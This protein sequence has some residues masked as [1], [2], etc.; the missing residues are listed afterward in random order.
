MQVSLDQ[1]RVAPAVRRRRI[2]RAFYTTMSLAVVATVIVGFARTYFLRSWF[3]DTALPLYLEIHGF[4]FTSWIALFVAQPMFV[5]S[6]R[7]D[8][9]RRLGW[10]GAV[11]ASSMV[12]VGITAAILSG[13]RDFADGSE[14]ESLTFLTT[15]FLSMLVFLILI[16]AAVL[17]RRVPEAHK[18][19]M[20]LGT[21]NILD[22]A[23]SRWPLALITTVSWAH[24]AIV[25]IFIVLG[26]AYDL[27]T[28]KRVHPAYL[29]GG[30]LI[31][32][33]QALRDVLGRSTA[34]HAFARLLIGQ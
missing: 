20:F 34:W 18:R 6:G 26:A 21:V 27:A 29:W 9:H 30:T 4:L 10:V 19:L 17:Y 32:A 12:I 23:V 22:A 8:I 5:A 2:D 13:R 15:P 33:G 3:E 28:R 25:D 31:V 14:Q 7:T 24:Y 1:Q 16:G 11:L